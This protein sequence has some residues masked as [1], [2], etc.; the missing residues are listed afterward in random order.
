MRKSREIIVTWV[1][2]YYLSVRSTCSLIM[3]RLND[4]DKD[5]PLAILYSIPESSSASISPLASSMCE[6][7]GSIG[8]TPGHRIA[9][10]SIDLSQEVDDYCFAPF[11][12]KAA[13][14]GKPT[15]V[16][17]DEKMQRATADIGELRL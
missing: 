9:P 7:E 5:I 12:R 8:V 17:L 11:F 15:V 6:L 3:Y 16:Y 14:D 13:T 10:M 1:H 2:D 4:A